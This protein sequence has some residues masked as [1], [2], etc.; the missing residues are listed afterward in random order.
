MDGRSE[1]AERVL[2]AVSAPITYSEIGD[3]LLLSDDKRCSYLW[4]AIYST[5]TDSRDVAARLFVFLGERYSASEL[6]RFSDE[7]ELARLRVRVA[8]EL[9]TFPGSCRTYALLE[10]I[11]EFIRGGQ[12]GSAKTADPAQR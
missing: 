12:L 2:R 1:D 11:V 7:D 10:P 9:G 6:Q 3:D 5:R 8:E 4:W